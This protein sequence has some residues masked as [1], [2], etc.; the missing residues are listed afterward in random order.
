MTENELICAIH[1]GIHTANMTLTKWTSDA[2]LSELA[3]E[4]FMVTY[5]MQEIMNLDSPPPFIRP[6][7][8]IS[9]LKCFSGKAH[10]GPACDRTGG[11]GRVDIA[12]F[13]SKNQLKF[14]IEAKCS[15]AWQESYIDD[16]KRLIKM[17]RE[18]SKNHDA[19][20]MQA[21][22]FAAFVHTYSTR[23]LERAEE[24]LESRLDDWE[25]KLF[26][27]KGRRDDV[28]IYC[29]RS[30]IDPCIFYADDSIHMATSLC[31]VVKSA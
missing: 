2:F 17:Q 18:F 9:E 20:A 5:I 1:Q 30:H 16:M 4:G 27:S 23:G 15:Y 10:K 12:T 29:S 21:G 22:I 26:A 31:A 6:E 8:R 3:A 24:Q 25:E 7:A 14:V 28:K 13:N 19:T 11:T